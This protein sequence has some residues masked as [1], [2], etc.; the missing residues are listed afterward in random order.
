MER[1]SSEAIYNLERSSEY[2]N[3]FRICAK[4]LE[5]NSR[6]ANS[7]KAPVIEQLKKSIDLILS[8]LL[9]QGR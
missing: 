7:K 9:G 8:R 5:S 2:P 3:G 4:F 1:V 6:F